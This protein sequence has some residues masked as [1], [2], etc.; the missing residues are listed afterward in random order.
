MRLLGASSLMT[1]KAS[2]ANANDRQGGGGLQPTDAAAPLGGMVRGCEEN[3]GCGS[4]FEWKNCS[5]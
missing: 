3:A 5:V 1:Q 4:L 2:P